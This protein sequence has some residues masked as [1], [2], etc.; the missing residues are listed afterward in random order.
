MKNITLTLLGIFLCIS[1][2]KSYSQ[3]IGVLGNGV[4]IADN[5]ATPSSADFTDFG[6]TT[7]R[8]FTIDNIQTS[9]N[10]TLNV[11]TI[12]LSN[13]V[14]FTITTNPAPV[15]VAK[16]GPDPT[17]TITLNTLTAGT[18]TSTVTIASSNAGNDG[19]DNVWIFTIRAVR[20]PEINIQGNATT[21]VDGDITPT[22]TD[23]TD[24]G[25]TFVGT[26]V[27]GP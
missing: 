11:L 25:S 16:N 15:G 2:S 24:F 21:I 26:P 12:S 4:Y 5:D 20:A 17:F 8:T 19:A 23:N 10:T 9:G 27:S 6:N 14:N 22:T 18:Y 3:E 1:F 13:P 7:A